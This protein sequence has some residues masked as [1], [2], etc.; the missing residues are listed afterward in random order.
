MRRS[1]CGLTRAF[2]AP[3]A[4]ASARRRSARP[5][6][7][8]ASA[9]SLASAW[10]ARALGR[11]SVLGP[12]RGCRRAAP[13]ARP[14]LRAVAGRLRSPPPPA[15]GSG[16]RR[17]RLSARRAGRFGSPGPP[18]RLRPSVSASASPSGC[19]RAR[20]PRFLRRASSWRA[21]LASAHSLGGRPAG[22][23]RSKIPQGSRA[24]RCCAALPR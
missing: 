11:R 4:G 3:V 1:A 23:G 16:C 7:G 2:V 12:R 20:G 22:A 14:C 10:P 5:P 19:P 13:R 24:V 9:A 17:S 6:R 8:L 18:L 15:L 21:R